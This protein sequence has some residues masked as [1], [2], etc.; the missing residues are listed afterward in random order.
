ME[1]IDMGLYKP[2]HVCSQLLVCRLIIYVYKY[3]RIP[4][5]IGS[6]HKHMYVLVMC[7]CVCLVFSKLVLKTPNMQTSALSLRLLSSR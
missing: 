6:V 3:I 1:H 4:I 5:Y 2:M 7:V